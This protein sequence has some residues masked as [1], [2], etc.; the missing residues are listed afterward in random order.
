M[1]KS[2]TI[3]NLKIDAGITLVSLVVTIVIL[4][5]LSG[6]AIAT[7]GGENGLFV[8]VKMSK[9]KYEISEA[10]EKIKLEIT[11]LQI[12]KQ[13]KG[14]ELTKEDLTKMN[15]KEIDVRD[16]TNFPVEVI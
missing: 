7:L 16:T 2:Y 3:K 14:E 9:E 11:N 6:I 4:L 13:G 15:N 10:K 1:K 8:R 12:E 5:I